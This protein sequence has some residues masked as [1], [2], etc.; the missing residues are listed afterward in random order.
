MAGG[1]GVPVHYRSVPAPGRALPIDIDLD[2]ADASAVVLLIDASWAGDPAWVAWGDEL[3]DRAEKA[4][5]R[6]RVFPVTIDAAAVAIGLAA[7]AARWDLWLGPF[8]G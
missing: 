7:Q 4:G 5:L 6:A 1:A 8:A 3:A 2:D